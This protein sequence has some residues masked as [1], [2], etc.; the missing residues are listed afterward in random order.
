[1]MRMT[2][3]PDGW[4]VATPETEEERDLLRRS[5]AAFYAFI[6]PDVVRVTARIGSS[7]KNAKE[8]GM[9]FDKIFAQ[10][11]ELCRIPGAPE[12]SICLHP[13]VIGDRRFDHVWAAAF[14]A[15]IEQWERND[16]VEQVTDHCTLMDERDEVRSQFQDAPSHETQV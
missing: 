2:K 7:K 4:Y 15:L 14:N 10:D 1:M 5:M 16:D 11:Q 3:L 12:G 8:E 13:I 9:S 6:D